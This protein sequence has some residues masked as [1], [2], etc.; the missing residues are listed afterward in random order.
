MIA[1]RNSDKATPH[2]WNAAVDPVA[3]QPYPDGLQ[4]V[5]ADNPY[6]MYEKRRRKKLA[7]CGVIV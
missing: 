4:D 3:Q 2:T 7:K 1:L 6:V 5:A